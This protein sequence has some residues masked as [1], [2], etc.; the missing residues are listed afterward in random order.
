MN[1]KLIGAV[2]G[3]LALGGMSLARAEE[4]APKTETPAKGKKSDKKEPVGKKADKDKKPGGEK[5]CG[6]AGGCGKK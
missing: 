4:P 2:L 3:S 6:G 1:K 5:S